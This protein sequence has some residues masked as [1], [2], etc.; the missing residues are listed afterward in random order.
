SRT[1]H[2]RHFPRSPIGFQS[3]ARPGPPAVCRNN[4]APLGLAHESTDQGMRTLNP[5]WFPSW[6]AHPMRGEPKPIASGRKL[7]HNMG[8]M[9]PRL[10]MKISARQHG[11]ITILDL[12]GEITLFNSP[13]IRKAILG[14]LRELRVQHLV[15][16]MQAVPYIDS[17]GVA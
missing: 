17:S 5:T 3:S 8:F 15:L 7:W 16:N 9:Q 11:E 1:R 14:Q 2:S 13:E 10:P 6:F 4:I 12:S